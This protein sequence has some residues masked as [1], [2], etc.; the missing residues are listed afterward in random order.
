MGRSTRNKSSHRKEKN[1]EYEIHS[2]KFMRFDEELQQFEEEDEILYDISD[3]F[4]SLDAG[5]FNNDF[6]LTKN[7]HTYYFKKD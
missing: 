4:L 7:E 6:F 5:A 3:N 1:L 2:L